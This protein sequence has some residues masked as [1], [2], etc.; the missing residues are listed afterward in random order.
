VLALGDLETDAQRA[1]AAS[2][3]ETPPVDVV[4]VAHHGSGKQFAPLYARFRP[5]VAVIGVGHDNDYG[6]P[7]RSA[8]VMLDRLGVR[9]LRTDEQG[10]LAV[11]GPADRLAAVTSR[12]RLRRMALGRRLLQRAPPPPGTHRCRRWRVASCPRGSVRKLSWN[13]KVGGAVTAHDP[14]ARAPPGTGRPRHG[15]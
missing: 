15:W 10:D 14:A 9:V 8:L 4:K 1:L 2:L 3:Q 6:H 12:R 13:P 11:T 7:T 5:R